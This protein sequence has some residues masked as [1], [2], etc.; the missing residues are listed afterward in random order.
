MHVLFVLNTSNLHK[1]THFHKFFQHEELTSFPWL[2][3]LISF[4][5]TFLHFVLT[6]ILTFIS[7]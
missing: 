4:L 6:G 1:V 3:W 7:T 5:F 2:P